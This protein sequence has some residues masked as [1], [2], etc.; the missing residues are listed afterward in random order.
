VRERRATGFDHLE[1]V[2]TLL[3]AARRANPGG[4]VWDAA[5]FQWAWRRDR[6]PDPKASTF[7]LDDDGA[8]VAALVFTDWGDHTGCDLLDARHDSQHALDVAGARFD[9]LLDAY[10]GAALEMNITVGDGA[11]VDAAVAHG[12]VPTDYVEVIT[13]MDAAAR[14]HPTALPDGF[15]LSSYAQRRDRPHHMVARSGDDVAERL[16]EC[17]LYRPDL[18]L[19]VIEA[20]TGAVAAYGL[21]WA[22][23][24]TGL[25][26]VE[27]MRTEDAF[28]G[29]GLASGLLRAGLEGLVTAGCPML[30]IIH[31]ADNEPAKRAYRGAGFRPQNECRTYRRDPR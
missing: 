25:G 27:P 3:Q 4:G 7:W 1:L 10:A 19:C 13:T 2:T 18:D 20:T 9:E 15:V 23:L 8:P 24:V 21:F 26:V 12:F 22:D 5:D 29:R 30:K 28:Q 11:L 31:A 17:S 16:A 6:H 14:E